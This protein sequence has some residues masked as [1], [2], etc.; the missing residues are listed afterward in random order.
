M[1]EELREPSQVGRRIEQVT[2]DVQRA[3]HEVGLDSWAVG[4]RQ[5]VSVADWYQYI[6]VAV[7]DKQRYAL[8]GQ[9]AHR[10]DRADRVEIDVSHESCHEDCPRCEKPRQAAA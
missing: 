3:R 8:L 7:D 5:A 4:I 10:I 1:V 9:A 6:G 2:L